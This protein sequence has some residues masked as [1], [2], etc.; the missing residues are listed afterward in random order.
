MRAKAG[1]VVTSLL[2][3]ALVPLSGCNTM[4][5]AYDNGLGM[6]SYKMGNHALARDHFRRAIANDP[7]NADYY[8]NLASAMR[9]QGDIAGAEQVYHQALRVDPSHQPS[10]HGLALMMKD[11][12]RQAEA[13]QLMTA[14][15]GS[16]PYNSSAYVE[17]AWLKRE[18]G[19]IA[20]SEALLQQA[21]RVNPH[22]HI[23]T[24][25]LGQL[26]QDTN[27]TDRAAAMY[28]VSL[29]KRWFQPEVQSR[30][31]TL[32][33]RRNPV[34]V[35][36]GYAQQPMLVMGDAPAFAAQPGIHHGHMMVQSPAIPTPIAQTAQGQPI[37][38]PE[39]QPASLQP[40]PMSPHVAD[41]AHANVE[42]SSD[43]PV[44][45]PH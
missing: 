21:R 10:Y 2:L 7:Q 5:G 17:T 42:I 40:V 3:A 34:L 6:R 32:E 35:P 9:K 41:P 27:Q 30:L 45:Q 8:H 28:K 24:A 13:M 38:Q 29:N 33:Q 31:A 19:D 36:P 1:C 4:H 15:V 22:D 37:L 16:Q 23:A 14:W 20:G 18:T 43:V 39:P 44:V 11:Q 25:Q 12:G 26:Y